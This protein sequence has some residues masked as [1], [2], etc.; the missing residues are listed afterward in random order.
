MKLLLIFILCSA[1]IAFKPSEVAESIV[2]RPVKVTAAAA[3][4]T[5]NN[6]SDGSGNTV[7][8]TIS[9]TAS[10][11]LLVVSFWMLA[12][13]TVS[14]VAD[15]QSSSYTIIGPVSSGGDATLK[16]YQAYAM[17]G[18]G[19]TSVTITGSAGTY[20]IGACVDEY[21]GIDAG[22]P[23]DVHATANGTGT[24]ASVS[25]T[26]AASGKLI[27]ASLG[28]YAVSSWAAGS[29]YTIYGNTDYSTLHILRS[30]YKLSSSASETAPATATYLFDNEWAEIATSFNLTAAP[31]N[32]GGFFNFFK[33]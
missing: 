32:T 6:T 4:Q 31:T 30:Q 25:L 19:V 20:I 18:S 9:S 22:D 8:V 12:A 24:S 7:S 21:S 16:I 29:G 1:F 28:G 5:A 11:S 10:N 26:P 13:N 3:V 17:C 33:P 2:R 14:T 23:Y 15:N 27:V